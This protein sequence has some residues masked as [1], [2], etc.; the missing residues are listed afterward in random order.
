MVNFDLGFV[1]DLF[2]LIFSYLNKCIVLILLEIIVVYW[3]VWSVCCLW[4]LGDE[5]RCCCCGW[6]WLLL[7]KMCVWLLRI[8]DYGDC[9]F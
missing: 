5:I 3:I 7:S 9:M 8:F 1:G 6:E 2:R 4:W